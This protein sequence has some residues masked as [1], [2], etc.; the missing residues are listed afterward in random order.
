MCIRDSYNTRQI[1]RIVL[2]L[3]KQGVTSVLVTHDMSSIFAV[4]DRVAFLKS[5]KI[6]ALG[7]AEEIRDTKNAELKGFILGETM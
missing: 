5:G 1:L 3:K 4:T 6:A 2:D 7:T